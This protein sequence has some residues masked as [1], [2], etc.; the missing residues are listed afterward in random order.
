MNGY[1]SRP[2]PVVT[3]VACSFTVSR[4]FGT[5]IVTAHGRLDPSSSDVLGAAL[6]DLIDNQGNLSVILDAHDLALAE[7]SLLRFL[8]APAASATRRGGRLRVADPSP[9][10]IAAL[11]AIGLGGAI[12]MTRPAA[13]QM[14]RPQPVRQGRGSTR[15]CGGRQVA[16]LAPTKPRGPR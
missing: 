16:A 11:E 2:T 12:A 10:V 5:V 4:A 8:V 9:P 14:A 15:S 6:A 1:W 13:G 3:P 7:P